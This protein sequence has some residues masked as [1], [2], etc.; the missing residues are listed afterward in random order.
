V[1]ASGKT[2]EDLNR[3]GEKNGALILGMY[4]DILRSCNALDYHDLINSSVK[5][6]TDFDE[7]LKECQYKWKAIV[8]DEFQDTS[9]MQYLLLRLLGSHNH[10]TI[11]GD[12]DQSI[13]SFNGADVSGFGSFRRDFPTH[14]E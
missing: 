1:K 14:K 10:I 2:P 5:L 6:L 4:N 7:V 12:E 11:V 3:S 8:V 9:S 13:F